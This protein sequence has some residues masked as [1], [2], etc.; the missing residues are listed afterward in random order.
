VPS[1]GSGLGAEGTAF[2]DRR[3]SGAAV[4]DDEAASVQADTVQVII[5]LTQPLLERVVAVR[6]P[7]LQL[8]YFAL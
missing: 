8:E 1:L 5:E 6:P 3:S 7:D 2:A 4:E